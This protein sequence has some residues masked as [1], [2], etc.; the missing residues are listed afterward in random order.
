MLV[1]L[2]VE[3]KDHHTCLPLRT[4]DQNNNRDESF[5]TK[6]PCFSTETRSLLVRHWHPT[7]DLTGVT[8]YMHTGLLSLTRDAKKKTQ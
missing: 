6:S 1:C 5:H 3:G 4:N 2:V 8:C 7:Y